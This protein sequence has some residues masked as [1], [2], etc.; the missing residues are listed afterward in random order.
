M[1]NLYIQMSLIITTTH[2]CRIC[3]ITSRLPF[4]F[5]KVLLHL[6]SVP[7]VFIFHCHYIIYI[8]TA[9]HRRQKISNPQLIKT[10][11]RRDPN[12]CS[13]QRSTFAVHPKRTWTANESAVRIWSRS[14]T[15]DAV[16]WSGFSS[17]SRPSCGCNW[18]WVE[19][20]LMDF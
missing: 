6:I 14:R 2:H 19:V 12:R 11:N 1:Y 18:S 15:P 16:S 20:N 10:S 3:L 13:R 4:V 17:W 5:F 8:T 9:Y 7:S